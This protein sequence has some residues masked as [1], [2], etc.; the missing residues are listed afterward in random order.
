[1]SRVHSSVV[2]IMRIPIPNLKSLGDDFL[3]VFFKTVF[4]HVSFFPMHSLPLSSSLLVRLSGIN[5]TVA[6]IKLKN[7]SV[8]QLTR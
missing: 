5:R 6:K 7:N 2:K 4:I 3:K 8:G 1:M